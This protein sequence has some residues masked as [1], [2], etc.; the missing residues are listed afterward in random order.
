MLYSSA[1]VR[2]PTNVSAHRR[3]FGS[4]VLL[5][6]TS[7][8][9]PLTA[10]PPLSPPVNTDPQLAPAVQFQLALAGALSGWQYGLIAAVTP[11][12]E[13]EEAK[14]RLFEAEVESIR[15]AATAEAKAD[16]TAAAGVSGDVAK[17]SKEPAL[18]A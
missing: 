6:T 10:P 13:A 18:A 8:H 5:L 15:A 7:V 17:K 1:Y 16:D 4:V 12:A 2:A 11:L 3:E 14:D 9:R